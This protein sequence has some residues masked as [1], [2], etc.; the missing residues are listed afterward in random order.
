MTKLTIV[1]IL[2]ILQNLS[3]SAK[4]SLLWFQHVC[5]WP[6]SLDLF[7]NLVHM[8]RLCV[9]QVGSGSQ[10]DDQLS[11]HSKRMYTKL[12]FLKTKVSYQIGVHSKRIQNYQI[13]GIFQHLC[14]RARVNRCLLE[15]TCK[16]FVDSSLHK[17]WNFTLWI[18][19]VNMNTF[20]SV[21]CG[22]VHTY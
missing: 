6:L 21:F 10:K 12:V 4:Y 15:S 14:S 3:E 11:E 7:W 20:F 5:V 18:Y 8:I 19:L 17:L 13:F 2:S 22:L 16:V 9:Y 1:P